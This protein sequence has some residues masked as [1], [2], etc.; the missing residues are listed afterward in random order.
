[1]TNHHC[2]SDCNT[3]KPCPLCPHGKGEEESC[4]ACDRTYMN[5][6][7]ITKEM[8]QAMDSVIETAQTKEWF[9]NLS[10]LS[11]E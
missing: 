9:K 4:E 3:H 10:K 11:D 1:M 5:P 7:V 2:T 6:D 8:Q